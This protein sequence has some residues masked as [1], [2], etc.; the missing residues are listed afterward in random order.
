MK[1]KNLILPIIALFVGVFSFSG[2]STQK[3][4]NMSYEQA[5]SILENQSREMI[6]SLFG[7]K[8]Q[9]KDINLS[10]KIDMDELNLDL[11]LLSQTKIDY[12]SKMEDTSLEFD[13]DVKV[14]ESEI[15]LTTSWAL[16]YSLIGDDIYLK[17][18]KF[19]LKWPSAKELAMVTM[20]VNSMKWQRFKLSISGSTVSKAFDLYDLYYKKLWD[21]TDKASEGVINEGAEVYN[22]MFDEY[23]WY[24]AWKY[25]VDEEK[26]NEM[27]HIYVDAMY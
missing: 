9:E 11:N 1:R 20:V 18:S 4:Y 5:V 13:A 26:F 17:L 2:C 7:F 16:N 6:D 15:D 27:L 3:N 23:K 25:S 24:N 19:S 21:M 8:A 10:T 22:W 14:P 12:D